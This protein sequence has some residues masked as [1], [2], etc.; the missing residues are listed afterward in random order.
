MFGWPQDYERAVNVTVYHIATHAYCFFPHKRYP[1]DIMTHTNTKRALRDA[2]N[3]RHRGH[4][5]T[6]DSSLPGY[7]TVA[8]PIRM[9][10]YLKEFVDAA[11]QKGCHSLSAYI[12]MVMRERA[13]R[14]MGITAKQWW[15]EELNRRAAQSPSARPGNKKN[16][17]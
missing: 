5:P 7:K 14:E 12:S 4:L 11:A 8:T 15:D 9:R 2:A 1:L 13:E 17:R 10:G 3:E 6:E 16:T